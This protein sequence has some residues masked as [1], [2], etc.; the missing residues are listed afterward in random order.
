MMFKY[1]S[2]QTKAKSKMRQM[3]LRRAKRPSDLDLHGIQR[4]N[5]KSMDST[6][7]GTPLILEA[8]ALS[9]PLTDPFLLEAMGGAKP[10]TPK[11]R[12][13]IVSQVH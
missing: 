5:S 1:L 8:S 9:N 11:P 6:A 4:L 10:S 3:L 7:S 2:L 13:K 12:R